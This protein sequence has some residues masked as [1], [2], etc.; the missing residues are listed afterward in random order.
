GISP[1]TIMAANGLRNPDLLQVG[2]DLVILPTDGVLYTLRQGDSLRRVADHYSVP[3]DDIVRANLLGPNPDLV[4]PG[5]KLMVPG[6]TPVLPR[7]LIGGIVTAS[8]DQQTASI[9]G[10]VGLPIDVTAYAVPSTRTYEVQPGDTLAG[11]AETF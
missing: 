10:S 4:Q 8:G 2:Q 5:T 3:V 9:G 1:E 7:R 11:I 6:A